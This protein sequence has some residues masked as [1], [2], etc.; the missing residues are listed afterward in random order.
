[1]M[2]LNSQNYAD[3]KI[4]MED[5][6]IVRDLYEPIDNAEIPKGVIESEW[7]LLNR[8][9]VATIRQYVDVSVLQHVANDTNAYE[10][11]K[12][13]SGLYERKNALN[14]TSLMRKIV[15]L[16]YRDGESMVEHVST[17]MGF[18]NQLAAIKFPLDDAMQA[19]MLMCT[20]PESWENL[21]V[22][23]STSCK[24]ENL[25]LLTV[26]TSI[27]N[28][29]ARRRDKEPASDSKALLTES[30]RGRQRNRSPQRREKS[31][32]R[33]QSRGRPTCFYCG[34][35]GHF[36]KNCRHFRKDNGT[37]G[38]DSKKS[39][40]RNGAYRGATDRRGPDR[41]GQ[42][43]KGTTGIAANDE[44]LMLITEE[45]ELNLAGDE[46]T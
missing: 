2:V 14:R 3:W 40:E 12:K 39:P 43:R 42:D 32:T 44:E 23:L 25:S 22:T 16:K 36:Q 13:L 27:L 26:K 33:S 18:V 20:L 38:T 19:I 8:K 29:E 24:E 30:E 9:A 11:W 5:L 1:M 45:S 6:L 46:I 17:F 7:K 41:R 10:M 31:G 15:N 37:D 21:V 35:P 34:K 28:E 4:K